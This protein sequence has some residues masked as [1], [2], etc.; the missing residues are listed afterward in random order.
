MYRNLYD[1]EVTTWSPQGRIHQ[2]E[3]AMEA[4]KQG[5]ATVG[6]KNATHAVL[7]ALKRAPSSL[8]S[9][10]KK[11]FMIDEHLGVSIAGLTADAQLLCRYLQNECLDH[12]YAYGEPMPISR[13]VSSLASKLQIPTQRYGRR[14]YGVGLLIAGYDA[15]G[16]HIYQTEPSA[17][18]FE[19]RAMAIGARAQSARTYLERRMDE[20][21][22]CGALDELVLHALRAL[23]DTL[24]NE[25]SLS[26]KNC[27]V[28]VVGKDT[29]FT[30][31]DET[32]VADYLKRIEHEARPPA[33]APEEE[34]EADAE[35]AAA[36]GGAAVRPPSPERPASPPPDNMDL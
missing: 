30:I 26:D 5:S 9:Y 25:L 6:M 7:V 23:R 35:G 36:A 11:I 3:Y 16:A 19:C 34:M 31:F 32:Q 13:L 20:V 12:K 27:S 1:H 4:V 17:N 24:P 28:A 18:F 22:A 15:A 10:Q 33:P 14:P 21:L 29:K 8:S 2:I